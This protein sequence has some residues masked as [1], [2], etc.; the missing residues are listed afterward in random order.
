MTP[1]IPGSFCLD[2]SF[3]FCTFTSCARVSPLEP[4]AGVLLP[5]PSQL[6]LQIFGRGRIGTHPAL[7]RQILRLVAPTRSTK[8]PV[9]SSSFEPFWYF[10]ACSA[11]AIQLGGSIYSRVLVTF[12]AVVCY[13]SFI[14]II[15]LLYYMAEGSDVF[16]YYFFKSCWMDDLIT[17]SCWIFSPTEY[18]HTQIARWQ[19]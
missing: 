12:M 11:L 17:R 6:Q 2:N 18:W 7:M 16:T 19:R 1:K 8:I 4:Q 10:K 14:P 3:P 9:K 15:R 13:V 5:N